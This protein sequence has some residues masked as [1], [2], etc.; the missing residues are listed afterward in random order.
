MFDESLDRFF[1]FVVA[2]EFIAFN[3]FTLQNTVKCF[4]IGIFFRC[5]YVC[6]FLPD[7]RIF[8]KITHFVSNELAAVIISQNDALQLVKTVNSP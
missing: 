2:S 6:K 4:D 5:R 7:F 8:Q 3:Y 1:C